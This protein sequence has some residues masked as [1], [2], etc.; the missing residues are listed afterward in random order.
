MARQTATLDSSWSCALAWSQV[1]GIRPWACLGRGTVT[2]PPAGST[3]VILTSLSKHSSGDPNKL[4]LPSQ[5]WRSESIKGTEDEGLYQAPLVSCGSVS[6]VAPGHCGCPLSPEWSLS[7]PRGKSQL[8]WAARVGDAVC[9]ERG[10]FSW[11]QE[12]RSFY[13]GS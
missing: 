3:A 10:A 7:L 6:S 9:P 13:L 4:N 12:L 8:V 5:E 1:P 2:L 11:D